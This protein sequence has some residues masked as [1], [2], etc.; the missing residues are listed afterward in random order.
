MQ[1]A[2]YFGPASFEV[3]VPN[4]IEEAAGGEE[5]GVAEGGAGGLGGLLHP[6]V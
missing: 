6:T 3:A 2:E 5:L 4:S 1:R